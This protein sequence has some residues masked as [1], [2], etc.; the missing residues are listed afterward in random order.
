MEIKF[1]GRISSLCEK[2]MLPTEVLAS[3]MD[4]L[5]Q[6]NNNFK[7]AWMYISTPIQTNYFFAFKIS[8]PHSDLVQEILVALH[9]SAL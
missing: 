2:P 4:K 1:K 3:G 9:I 5:V 7:K 8:L 6:R